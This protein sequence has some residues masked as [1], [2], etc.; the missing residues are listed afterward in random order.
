M[1]RGS[2]KISAVQAE[3]KPDAERKTNGHSDHRRHESSPISA[4]G[5]GRASYERV[6]RWERHGVV[7]DESDKHH[8]SQFQLY[9]KF[10]Y[11]CD[12]RRTDFGFIDDEGE[13]VVFSVEYV[14]DGSFG[15]TTVSIGEQRAQFSNSLVDVVEQPI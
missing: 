7:P 1:L 6:E 4:A 14:G 11:A 9:E 15:T 8:V 3:E 13:P 10:V 2:L 12:D 5:A